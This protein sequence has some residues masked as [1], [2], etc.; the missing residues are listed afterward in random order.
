MLEMFDN[1][2]LTFLTKW[3]CMLPM[4]YQIIGKLLSSL[5]R[6]FPFS[7]SNLSHLG[8]RSFI[9]HE[10]DRWKPFFGSK[11]KALHL[12]NLEKISVA[13]F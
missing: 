6:E 5:L 11:C 13:F 8:F 10:N 9:K 12:K 3:F 7:F 4:E 1:P 2:D